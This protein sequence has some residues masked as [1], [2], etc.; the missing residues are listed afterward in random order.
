MV[1]K[2][3]ARFL[4]LIMQ[5]M[6]FISRSH[7]L[8]IDSPS[9]RHVH[10]SW[11]FFM[12]SRLCMSVNVT[13]VCVVVKHRIRLLSTL[14]ELRTLRLS[15]S[16]SRNIKLLNVQQSIQFAPFNK[17]FLESCFTSWRFQD[18]FQFLTGS[19]WSS[20]DQSEALRKA[21]IWKPK[22]SRPV[23]TKK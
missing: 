10:N 16:F 12:S 18:F 6:W 15:W 1:F 5:N 2:M 8:L 22:R 4:T 23:K 7:I 20:T 19:H 14:K 3:F 17:A 9:Q 13:V 21:L 11:L